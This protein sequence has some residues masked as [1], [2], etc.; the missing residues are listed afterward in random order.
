MATTW[1]KPIH[2]NKNKSVSQTLAERIGYAENPDKTDNYEHVKSYGCDYYTAANEFAIAKTLYEQHTGRERNGDDIIAYHIRQ[3]FKPGEVEPSEALEIGYKLCEKFTHGKHQFV[4]SVHTDRQHIHCHCVFNAVNLDCDRKF[5]N[6]R[7]SMRIVRQIS[8]YL[9][10]E[11]G[12]SIIE[13][14]QPSHGSYADWMDK[15]EP[16]TN[17]D[18]LRLLIDKLISGGLMFEQFIGEMYYA[19]C[20]VKREKYL[21]FKTP[22]AERFIRVKS[23]GEDYTEQALRERCLGGRA[24]LVSVPSAS[25]HKPSLLTLHRTI[26]MRNNI[27]KD[28][29]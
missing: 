28:R 18:K 11:H 14:P 13:N 8:D 12:L 17:K 10:A 29:G 20:E 9:C 23:L 27:Y 1:I 3:S 21:A 7:G 26:N 16:A 6:V 25:A 5:R 24:T 4:V 19:G 22:G 15:K 2:K